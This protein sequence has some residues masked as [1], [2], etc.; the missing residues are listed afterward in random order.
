MPD[1]W[2]YQV[3]GQVLGPLSLDDLQR[4]LADK[5]LDTGTLVRNGD[6][7]D[8]VL[9]D[10]L[11]KSPTVKLPLKPATPPQP[12]PFPEQQLQVDVPAAPQSPPMTRQQ[13][14]N[15]SGPSD[16]GTKS[17]VLL[18]IGGILIVIGVFIYMQI[19]GED[20]RH[21]DFQQALG[22]ALGRYKT[23]RETSRLPAYF[24]GGVGALFVALGIVCW[25]KE[26]SP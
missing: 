15:T 23:P 2:Y 8:W 20:A 11:P 24:F 9:A 6:D 18:V 10:R 25:P 1:K 17:T 3:M 19:S 14:T 13:V 4:T 26:G 12:P 22:D 5:R 16:T 21:N 7:G